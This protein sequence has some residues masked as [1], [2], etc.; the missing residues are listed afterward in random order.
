M[1]SPL[2]PFIRDLA[3][4]SGLLS[5]A[6]LGLAFI[7]VPL[8]RAAWRLALY[9]AARHAARPLPPR[10]KP[11]EGHPDAYYTLGET[12]EKLFRPISDHYDKETAVEPKR[13]GGKT[14]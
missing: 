14:K 3:L 6:V 1:P 9:L 13:R 5:F 7:L 8:S 11:A 12:D 2:W 10:D 4:A